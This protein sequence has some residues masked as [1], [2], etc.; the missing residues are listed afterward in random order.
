MRDVFI[1]VP[2]KEEIILYLQQKSYSLLNMLDLRSNILRIDIKE[3]EELYKNFFQGTI[4]EAKCSAL[5]EKTNRPIKFF[6]ERKK[7]VLSTE[8]KNVECVDIAKISNRTLRKLTLKN[9]QKNT[10]YRYVKLQYKNKRAFFSKYLA[11]QE[12]KTHRLCCITWI[13]EH[14]SEPHPHNMLGVKSILKSLNI[15]P[16]KEIKIRKKTKINV[17]AK[18]IFSNFDADPEFKYTTSRY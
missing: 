11:K 16:V 10:G 15:K 17:E 13:S 5:K 8:V 2:T 3:N 12:N 14:V 7:P 4:L 6:Y 9:T 18:V 1:G